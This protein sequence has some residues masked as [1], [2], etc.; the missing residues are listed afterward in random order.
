MVLKNIPV[1]AGIVNCLTNVGIFC[2]VRF[3]ELVFNF[4][5]EKRIIP[6]F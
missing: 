6:L 3:K 4:L 2:V 5:I 1:L